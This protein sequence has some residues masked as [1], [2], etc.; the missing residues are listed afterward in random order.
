MTR[1]EINK[2]IRLLTGITQAELAKKVEVS[3]QTISNYE[4]GY[5]TINPVQRVI[6][7]ELDAAVE[8]IDSDQIKE[9]CYDLQ[10]CRIV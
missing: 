1:C 8:Q 10:K 7:L 6:E 5:K 3:K 2:R 4:K 9:I